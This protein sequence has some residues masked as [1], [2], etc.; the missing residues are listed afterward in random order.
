MSRLGLIFEGASDVTGNQI[1]DLLSGRG[2]ATHAQFAVD[3]DN[4]DVNRGQQIVQ[5]IVHGSQFGVPIPQLLVNRG[6]LFVGTLELLW[7]S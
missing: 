4:R 1:K 2:D 5:I 7:L 6:Q 3:D